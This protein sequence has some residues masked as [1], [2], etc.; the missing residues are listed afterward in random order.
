MVRGMRAGWYSGRARRHESSHGDVDEPRAPWSLWAVRVVCSCGAVN[1]AFNPACVACGQRVEE[2]R[3]EASGHLAGPLGIGSSIGG[4]ELTALLGSGSLGRVFRAR[5]LSRGRD[6]AVKAL[7]P[8][9]VAHHETRQRFL[10]EARAMRAV[11]HPSLGRIHDVLDIGGHLALVLELHEAPSLREI[12]R[13]SPVLPEGCVRA[14]VR[15]TALGLGALHD[16]GWV[17]R[18]VK[19]ENL[20]V[21]DPESLRSVRLLDFGLARSF[22]AGPEDVRTAS[23]AF[24][25]SLAYASP[26]QLLGEPVDVATDWWSLGV[27]THEMLTGRSPFR[28]ATRTELARELL[29]AEAEPLSDVAPDLQRLLGA[30]LRREPSARVQSREQ[31]LALL[32]AEDE[33]T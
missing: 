23:G 14:L 18:D 25:G 24:I 7:H 4:L 21:L 6:V 11:E 29:R 27:M 22:D 26:E 20:L 10:R 1:S 28:G 30:L 5:D 8:H 16:A 33:T 3:G 9:L 32:D 2:A 15:E 31:V 19:P 12:L 17:H 13:R